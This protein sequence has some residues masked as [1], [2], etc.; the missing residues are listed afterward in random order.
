MSRS[1]F[2]SHFA[3]CPRGLEALLAAELSALGA[4]GAAPVPGGVAF[5]ADTRGR[6]RANLESRLATRVLARVGESA[7]RSEE[8][9]YRAAR[10]LDWPAM[11]SV[12]RSLRVDV[13]AVRSP[14]KSLDFVTLRIKDA[15]CD[16]FRADTGARPD[17]DTRQPGV[18]IHAFLDASRVILYLDTSGEP[19]YKRGYRRSRGE[20]PLKENLAAG[21]V[22]LSG[23]RPEEPFIDPM[24]GAGTLAIE[25]AM[26]ALDIAPGLGRAFGFER[27]ADFDASLWEAVQRGA[28]EAAAAARERRPPPMVL[29][30]DLHYREVESARGNLSAAGLEGLVQLKQAQLTD[31]RPPRATLPGVIV[32]NPP[33][34]VRLGEREA[35]ATLYAGIG[36]WLKR[37]FAGWRCY[38]FS[39]DPQLPRSIRL[40]ATRR[41][42]LYNGAIECRLLEYRMVEGSLRRKTPGG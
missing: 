21:L 12:E 31:L 19:L 1:D 17:V 27:L 37:H 36:D 22:A 6:Y 14:L 3:T 39:G 42:P 4:R 10:A 26:R 34:G 35:L 9:V 2:S 18:R 20:A 13:S 30:S 32:M 8:D 23:W 5:E 24:C 33:Y 40:R 11:F 29:A 15:V 7:Y 41:T 38:L 16:R 25:A 28:R